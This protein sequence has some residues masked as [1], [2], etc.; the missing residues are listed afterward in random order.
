MV[1]HRMSM[2]QQHPN[3]FQVSENFTELTQQCQKLINQN[4]GKRQ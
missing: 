4:L 3:H 2:T 1:F